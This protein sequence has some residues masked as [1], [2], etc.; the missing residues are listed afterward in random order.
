MTISTK[1]LLH[2]SK[3]QHFF[4]L[5]PCRI[6][7]VFRHRKK[8]SA[9]YASKATT[10]S[11]IIIKLVSIHIFIDH[12]NVMGIM[13]ITLH[14]QND[15]CESYPVIPHICFNSPSIVKS[16]FFFILYN[17]FYAVNLL[18]ITAFF[19]PFRPSAIKSQHKKRFTILTKKWKK[20]YIYLF[21]VSVCRFLIPKKFST[22]LQLY[23]FYHTDD[24]NSK[25]RK[26]RK[27]G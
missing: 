10:K 9:K 1:Q 23:F 16:K 11:I 20:Y 22:S 27:K 19:S 7:L 13:K 4:W 25:K 24:K 6:D 12:N 5:F 8:N 21:Y 17:F 26:N 3:I 18:L 15:T 14:N 2:C